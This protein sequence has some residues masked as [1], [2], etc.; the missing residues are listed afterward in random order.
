MVP[1]AFHSLQAMAQ[2]WQPTHT[3]RSMTNPSLILCSLYLYRCCSV[4]FVAARVVTQHVGTLVALVARV[5]LQHVEL[6][7]RAGLARGSFPDLHA[8]VEPRRLAGHRVGVGD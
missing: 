5:G 4:L 6:R 2:A 7:P 3:S 1:E 8:Q